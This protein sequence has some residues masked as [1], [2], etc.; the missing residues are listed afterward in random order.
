MFV[1]A[2]CPRS[3]FAGRAAAALG[4]ALLFLAVGFSPLHAH[5]ERVV[6]V[7]DGPLEQVPRYR[8]PL[9]ED[10]LV[11]CKPDSLQR[12]RNIEDPAR[13]QQA[14]KLLSECGFNHVQAAVNAV[15][16]RGYTIYVL[17][18]LYREEPSR[19]ARASYPSDPTCSHVLDEVEAGNEITYEQQLQCPHAA[20]LIAVL[21][22]TN[23]A[24]DTTADRT[25][26][27]CN[28]RWCRLQI[29]GMGDDPEDVLLEGGFNDTGEF[30]FNNV[31]RGDRAGGL[32]V[33]NLTVQKYHGNGIYMIE[34]DGFA[35]DRVLARWGEDYGVLT[36]AQDHG[37]YRD[38]E[39]Y[40]N[41]DAG[42][43]P[44]TGSEIHRGTGPEASIRDRYSVEIDNCKSHHNVLGYSGTS[45]NDAWIHDSE[46]YRNATGLSHDS[47]F[48][49][50]PGMPQHHALYED[51][52]IYRNNVDYYQYARDGTCELPPRDRGLV[53][54]DLESI[55]LCP[56]PPVPVGTGIIMAGGNYNQFRDNHVFDN[57]RQGVMM[58]SIPDELRE[59]PP[60]PISEW[61]SWTTSHYNRFVNNVMGVNPKGARALI[62]PNGLD[63]WWGTGGEGNC[64][65][66]NV[67]GDT[68]PSSSGGVD[69]VGLTSP[70]SVPLTEVSS[71]PD[72]LPPA[73]SAI[74]CPD[75]DLRVDSPSENMPPPLS[76]LAGFA[77]C[78]T[79]SLNGD[80]DPS[81]CN[82]FTT[83]PEPA[84]RESAAS[85]PFGPGGGSC[86]IE[87]AGAPRSVRDVLRRGRDG[88]L[89]TAVGRRLT[90]L[91][92]RF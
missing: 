22:D 67:A 68:D 37:L 86:L 75:I 40:G 81:P 46:F 62:Q 76:R 88:L 89:N 72:T 42:L 73:S 26:R 8:P 66:D 36:F 60:P 30:I 83:P 57:W 1:L 38:C 59:E 12:I 47:V 64:W 6:V 18:G 7:P 41:G 19:Q 31:L 39:A 23:T 91:Y 11:V 63:F 53:T 49:D 33:R 44:G 4:L 61:T 13:Q 14:E 84:G 77:G 55:V 87:R 79:Y 92:Y 74:A 10:R 85:L 32:F 45:G 35:I 52:L 24:D 9:Q 65:L 20:N 78:L 80:T 16:A 71:D 29:Q 21:G 54:T 51:N 69:S 5:D 50:H 15:P 43:Y 3:C 90:A 82:W 28:S 27:A 34:I 70:L 58:F 17:P 2:L 25:T 56:K 48:P